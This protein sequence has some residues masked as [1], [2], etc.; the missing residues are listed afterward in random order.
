MGLPIKDINREYFRTNQDLGRGCSICLN[1]FQDGERWIAHSNPDSTKYRI[2]TRSF[3]QYIHPMHED[4]YDQLRPSGSDQCPECRKIIGEP[5]HAPVR[6]PVAVLAPPPPVAPPSPLL[7]NTLLATLGS[8]LASL[9]SGASLAQT[10]SL[11]GI[12]YLAGNRISPLAATALSTALGTLA[13]VHFA[14]AALAT[15]LAGTAIGVETLNYIQSRDHSAVV[16]GLGAA[17]TMLKFYFLTSS[18]L[19]LQLSVNAAISTIISLSIVKIIDSKINS[20][21]F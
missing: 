1:T 12:T 11:G 10:A 2:I 14:T 19:G 15:V 13:R 8:T 9:T 20:A 3:H 7:N 16:L 4:C 5:L 6:A 21:I 17:A 18:S